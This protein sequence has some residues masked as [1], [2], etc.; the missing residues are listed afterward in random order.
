MGVT[1]VGGMLLEMEWPST[2]ASSWLSL[3]LALSEKELTPWGVGKAL[4]AEVT[5]WA[6]LRDTITLSMFKGQKSQ[7][8][9]NV[10]SK[11]R[12][13]IELKEEKGRLYEMMSRGGHGDRVQRRHQN[14]RSY[15][16]NSSFQ[17]NVK[18]PWGQRSAKQ[19]ANIKQ[20]EDIQA[21]VS[22]LQSILINA[23]ETVPNEVS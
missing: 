16:G 13:W 9:C 2:A 11:D 10:E 17:T 1:G 5:A 21:Q 4:Q 22:C 14:W 6:S 23:R 7:C 8:V 15:M 3:N 20:K 19:W 12:V 18:K